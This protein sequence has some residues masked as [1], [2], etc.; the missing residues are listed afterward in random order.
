[1]RATEP[2]GPKSPRC[3]TFRCARKVCWWLPSRFARCWWRWS[4]S[5]VSTSNC[6]GRKRPWSAP[7]KCAP[8]SA[9]VL[10]Q[11]GGRRD[12]NPRL[13]A[14]PRLRFP[15]AL[16]F[17]RGASC[18]WILQ[19]LHGTISP[20]QVPPPGFRGSARPRSS[21][22]EL[23]QRAPDAARRRAAEFGVRQSRDGR[24]APATRGHAGRRRQLLGAC[25]RLKR[26]SWSTGCA[27]PFSPAECS[28]CS[29]AFWASLLFTTGIARR[30]ERLVE[31][32]HD[33]AAGR[34]ISGRFTATT[35][36]ATWSAPC[37]RLP[38]CWRASPPNCAP[39]KASWNRASTTAPP[40]WNP[41]TKNCAR[42]KR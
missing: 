39:A 26:A 15:R 17:A 20:E 21:W 19:H 37:S 12:G 8:T 38:S 35:N 5:T 1:M 28:A 27:R 18:R 16:R 25:T 10:L 41:P 3:L 42:P 2:E 31:Q 24:I 4:S 23:A 30:I 34:V 36:S 32:A 40:S 29:A 7:P 22:T 14:H 9:P 33:V 11:H 6:G 13:P